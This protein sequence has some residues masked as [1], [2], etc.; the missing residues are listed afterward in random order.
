MPRASRLHVVLSIL[1][2]L[3]VSLAAVAD[4]DAKKKLP[5]NSVKSKTIKDGQ[6]KAVDVDPTQIQLRL[7]TT[8]PTGQALKSVAEDGT[9]G[10]VGLGGPPSGAAGGSLSGSYPNPSI[11]AGAVDS[12]N[13][14]DNSL[15]GT[16]IDESSLN[17]FWRLGGN[18][19]TLGAPD[20]LGTS[21][22]QPLVFRVNGTTA[23]R[24]VPSSGIPNLIM[25]S[26]GN[27]VTGGAVGSTIAGGGAAGNTS[28]QPN[29]ISAD[30][31]VIG[32]GV[33]NDVTG[34]HGVVG[35]GDSNTAGG[36]AAVV[37]GGAGN[38]ASADHTGI[39]GGDGNTASASS[40]TVGGGL[41]NSAT[42]PRA[43]VGGGEANSAAGALAT[44]SGG[45]SNT[46]GGGNAAVGG[47]SNNDATQTASVVSGGS[48][49]TASAATSA[50]GGGLSNTAS[51]IDSTVPG[52]L[53]NTASGQYSVA[54]GRRANANTNGTF[55]FSDGN[56]FDFTP[57]ASNQFSVRSTGG[58]RFVSGIDGSGVPTTGVKL[59]AG[60]SAWQTLSDRHSKTN[61]AAVDGETVLA[62]L[63]RLPIKTWSWKGQ[64][65][66]IHMGPMAQR[67]SAAFG[68]GTG[69]KTIS[70]VDPDGVALAAIQ[71]LQSKL[72]AERSKR[73]EL[74]RRVAALERQ[75]TGK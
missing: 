9:G 10:C 48:G 36:V 17:G 59:V 50:V 52:G 30:Y 18:A 55:V 66:A 61:I 2:A 63:A 57:T 60:D 62:K 69:N 58:V 15:T 6:V 20:F 3:F 70:T 71:G 54:M 34:S 37:S 72:R 5:K 42:Q 35:G 45:S 21:D 38:S 12:A 28:G 47:G 25:G 40:A 73:L 33:D 22:N 32:G 65:R 67:F 75:A 27:Q 43:T 23:M 39:G 11:G 14:F 64:R 7:K 74:E 4:V 56:D 31:S 8:C 19:G 68:L 44:V 49:N 41:E 1:C 16:D 29:T 51:G 26:A 46:A 53:S 24:L 13:V